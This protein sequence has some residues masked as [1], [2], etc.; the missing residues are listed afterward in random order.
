M[1]KIKLIFPILIFQ[2][3]KFENSLKITTSII[4]AGDYFQIE[5]LVSIHAPRKE[6]PVSHVIG[7]DFS[8]FYSRS[9][10]GSDLP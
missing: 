2:G 1:E 5:T 9:P 6:R 3:V 8:C 10:E 7:H 4:S